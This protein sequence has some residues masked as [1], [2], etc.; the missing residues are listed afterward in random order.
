MLWVY[1]IWWSRKFKDLL[2]EKEKK[3]WRE[4]EKNRW[5][6]NIATYLSIDLSSYLYPYFQWNQRCFPHDHEWLYKVLVMHLFINCVPHSHA[7]FLFDSCYLLHAKCVIFSVPF[8]CLVQSHDYKV[9]Q[10]LEGFLLMCSINK[11]NLAARHYTKSTMSI[12]DW[13]QMQNTIPNSSGHK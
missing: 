11:Y 9:E 5:I 3:K 4:A 2:R 12:L 13:L 6:K 7:F 8:S 10:N 1:I